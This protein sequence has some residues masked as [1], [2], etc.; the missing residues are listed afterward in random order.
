MDYIIVSLGAKLKEIEGDKAKEESIQNALSLFKCEKNLDEEEFLHHKAIFFERHNKA[1]TYLLIKNSKIIAYFSIAFKSIDLVTISKNK[2]K[3][4]TAG[5]EVE[6]YSSYLIGHIAKCDGV[7][8][9]MFLA[10]LDNAMSL[11]YE[12]QSIIGGRLVYLD[13]KNEPKLIEKYE[14]YGFEYFGTSAETGLR[15]YYMK[16]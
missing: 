3:D 15:Q 7:E 13:C 16:I 8:E 9:K 4:I 1:R 11:I 2:K 14:E 5:E 12:A 10:L 6:T